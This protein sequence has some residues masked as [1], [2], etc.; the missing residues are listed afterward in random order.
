MRLFWP[1][2]RILFFVLFLSLVLLVHLYLYFSLVRPH[3]E[4][5]T[6]VEEQLKVEQETLQLLL[7]SEAQQ[8]ADV[9]LDYSLEQLQEKLPSEPWQDYFFVL[10]NE[11][12]ESTS[13]EIRSITVET[14]ASADLSGAIIAEMEESETESNEINEEAD[15]SEESNSADQQFAEELAVVEGLA[16]F[17]L[18]LQLE[19]PNYHSLISFV[20]DLQQLERIVKVDSFNFRETNDGEE[21]Q[22]T[23]SLV[24]ST[25]YYPEIAEI[26]SDYEPNINYPNHSDKDDPFR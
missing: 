10:L 12:S 19:A 15:M 1:K 17:R 26:A 14:R 5:A 16:S 11:I 6:R 22:L 4:Q 23:A 7:G 13:T 9:E 3:S 21:S 20:E 25:F 8:G 18:S 24:V 2:K